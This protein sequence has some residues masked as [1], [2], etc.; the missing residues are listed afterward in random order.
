MIDP[1]IVTTLAEIFKQM[2][3]DEN[4]DMANGRSLQYGKSVTQQLY[5]TANNIF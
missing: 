4:V 1:Q 3:I 5:N 2:T